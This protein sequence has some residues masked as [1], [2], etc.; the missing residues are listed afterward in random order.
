[1]KNLLIC[2][3]QKGWMKYTPFMMIA[4]SIVFFFYFLATMNAI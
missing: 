3:R 1:M 2:S 4:A